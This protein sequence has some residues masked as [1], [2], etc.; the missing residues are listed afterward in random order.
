MTHYPQFSP[1]FQSLPLLIS[2]KIYAHVCLYKFIW[3]RLQHIVFLL[4]CHKV[5]KAHTETQWC[6]SWQ[7]NLTGNKAIVHGHHV[8]FVTWVL[9]IEGKA[10]KRIPFASSVIKSQFTTRNACSMR[11][12]L[13]LW[14]PSCLPVL[15]LL[16]SGLCQHQ[17]RTW[18]PPWEKFIIRNFETSSC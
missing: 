1:F 15:Y 9:P 11:F 5:V 16:E 17:P 7:I 14:H 6:S 3:I 18:S 4:L 10:I 13:S 8:S 12:P 2:L